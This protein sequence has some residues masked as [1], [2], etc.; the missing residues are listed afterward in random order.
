MYRCNMC[1]KG[2][3]KSSHLKQHIRSHTGEKPYGCNLCGRNFV[4][5]GV[6]KS[7]L[8]THTG[9]PQLDVQPISYVFMQQDKISVFLPVCLSAGVKAFKCNVCDSSFTTNGSLNRHLII[10]LNTKPFRCTLCEQSFRTHLL[11]RKHMK[12]YH[13]VGPRGIT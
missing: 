11:R 5:T 1:D 6:L 2:F 4:S 7:H 8:N 9:N 13:A 3:K 12:L 10:H